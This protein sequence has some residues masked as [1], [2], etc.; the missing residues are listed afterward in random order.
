MLQESG[1]ET[2]KAIYG[3]FSREIA[4]SLK[5]ARFGT[6][7]SEEERNDGHSVPHLLATDSRV[8]PLYG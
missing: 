1:E 6:V 3:K 7:K 4:D 2:R 8:I 5:K